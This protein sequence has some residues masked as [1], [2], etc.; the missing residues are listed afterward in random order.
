MHAMVNH[1]CLPTGMLVHGV[2]GF[3]LNDK[4]VDFDNCFYLVIWSTSV[5]ISDGF[6]KQSPF[7]RILRTTGIVYAAQLRKTGVMPLLDVLQRFYSQL[8]ISE[9]IKILFCR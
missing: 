8:L 5:T 1:Q 2:G 6:S 4:Q 7:E 9:G 3:V